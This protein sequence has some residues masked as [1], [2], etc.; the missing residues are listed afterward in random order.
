MVD[1]DNI[2]HIVENV[3]SIGD[4]IEKSA[5]EWKSQKEILY[6]QTGLLPVADYEHPQLQNSKKRKEACDDNLE[7]E[8]DPEDFCKELEETLLLQPLECDDDEEEEE[9]DED[10]CSP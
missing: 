1:V 4:V 5:E 2:K 10:T 7:E 6:R 8:E 3:S 9:A